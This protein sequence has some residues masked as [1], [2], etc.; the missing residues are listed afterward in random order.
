MRKLAGGVYVEG[1]YPGV[2]L[3]ALVSE[4]GIVMIDTPLRL[5]DGRSWQKELREKG[6]G[7]DR[8]LI[9]L[10]SHPD[11]TL[12]ARVMDSLVLAHQAVAD[13]FSQRPA[14]FKAQVAESGAEWETC[15]G[16][17][18]TRWSPPRLLYSKSATLFWGDTPLVVEHHPGP[19]KGSSWVVFPELKIVFVGDHV[20]VKQPP[21][22]ANAN[23]KAWREALDL[24]LS[25]EYEAYKIV[26]GRGGMAAEKDIRDLQKFLSTV[27][28]N[29]E[30]LAKR[31]SSPEATKKLVDKLLV[32]FNPPAKSK[33]LYS[34]RLKYGL[35]HCYSRSYHSAR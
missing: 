17:S 4:R 18:G 34:Q 8:L 28:K 3:G 14:I 21:F 31:K 12:G 10:D 23:L 30:R 11:R 13:A 29:L 2:T 19:E 26:G 22:L 27:Q 1:S 20:V 5:E 33:I 24:L 6:G 15:T 32:G 16:L 7:G 25:K 35:Y 9:S